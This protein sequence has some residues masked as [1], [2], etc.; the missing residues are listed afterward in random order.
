MIIF[1]SPITLGLFKWRD[2]VC[3]LLQFRKP[4]QFWCKYP[5]IQGWKSALQLHL[6]IF[7][8]KS[9]VVAYRGKIIKIV[10]LSKY[11]QI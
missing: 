2:Y 9:I 8:F 4:F 5:Q 6:D 11:F 3:K 1:I 7:N 10:S